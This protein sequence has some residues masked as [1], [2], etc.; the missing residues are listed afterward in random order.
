MKVEVL[1]E[2]GEVLTEF[3]TDE[4]GCFKKEFALAEMN[5]WKDRPAVQELT[6]R[7]NYKKNPVVMENIEVNYFHKYE[8]KNLHVGRKTEEGVAYVLGARQ[9][10][11]K[12]LMDIWRVDFTED[13]VFLDVPDFQGG[14]ITAYTAMEGQMI[15]A[16]EVIT[17]ELEEGMEFGTYFSQ[18]MPEHSL[19]RGMVS[20]TNSIEEMN[21]IIP[22]ALTKLSLKTAEDI[23]DYVD[24][25]YQL[26]HEYPTFY[27]KTTNSLVLSV[28]VAVVVASGAKPGVEETE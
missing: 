28:D 13:A 21:G 6:L 11:D 10:G 26:G 1:D 19:L 16:P 22:E 24:A 20:Y 27:I 15:L 3:E 2:L 18:V 8:V 9:S 17:V 4:E 23:Q 12:V 14:S 7:M 5:V 25:Y